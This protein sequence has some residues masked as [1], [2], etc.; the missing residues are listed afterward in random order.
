MRE[1]DVGPGTRE[2]G[3][4]GESAFGSVV[5]E[6]SKVEHRVD[7]HGV[8]APD[9]GRRADTGTAEVASSR[10]RSEG[11]SERPEPGEQGIENR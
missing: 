3:V 1:P 8:E 2:N 7:Q 11:Q 4:E 5:V 6:S 9:T 10:G